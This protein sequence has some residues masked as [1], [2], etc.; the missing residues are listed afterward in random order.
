MLEDLDQISEIL[1][2]TRSETQENELSR[3]GSG[4]H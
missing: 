3:K 4:S 1:G 2:N